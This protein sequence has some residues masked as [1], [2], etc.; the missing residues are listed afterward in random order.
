MR[1]EWM[2]AAAAALILAAGLGAGS[3]AAATVVAQT[4]E[5]AA[6]T[7]TASEA[8]AGTIDGFRSARFGASEA[9]VLAAITQDFGVAEADVQREHNPLEKTTALIV[10]V[11][12]MIPDSGKARIAYILGYKTNTLIQVNVVWG[13]PVVENPDLQQL[14]TTGNILQRYFIEQRYVPESVFTN[15]VLADKSV[16]IFTGSDASGRQVTLT[17]GGATAATEEAAAEGTAGEA[18]AAQPQ[19]AFLR[20]SYVASP[21][22]PDV[23]KIAPGAF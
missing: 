20:L 13:A 17:L 12:D 15:R 7:D 16:L 6:A 21:G 18:V 19:R 14:A 4:E 9:E 3:V 8:A 23:F 5:S 10:E 1:H 2:M 22:N 11:E